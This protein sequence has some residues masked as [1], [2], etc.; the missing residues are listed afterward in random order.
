V[1]DSAEVAAL[2]ERLGG[3]AALD[4]P[5]RAE[6]GRPVTTR[7]WLAGDRDAYRSGA[8]IATTRI[9]GVPD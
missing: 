2:R 9:V 3:L 4:W 5:P 6:I 1:L 8:S 7:I